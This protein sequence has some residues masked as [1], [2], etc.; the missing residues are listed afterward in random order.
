M[1]RSRTSASIV[2][3]SVLLWVGGVGIAHAGDYGDGRIIGAADR[4][5]TFG[6]GLIDLGHGTCGRVHVR[7]DGSRNLASDAWS[8]GS[9]SSA[10]LRSDGTIAGTTTTHL[11]VRGGFEAYNPFR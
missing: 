8:G 11:R 3:A 5:A 1:I 9:T 6:P 2:S 10:A 4:C 7:V